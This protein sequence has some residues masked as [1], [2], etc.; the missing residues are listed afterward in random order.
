MKKWQVRLGKKVSAGRR[1]SNF[2]Q[3]SQIAAQQAPDFSE[4]TP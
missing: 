1:K 3:I 2:S 4:H